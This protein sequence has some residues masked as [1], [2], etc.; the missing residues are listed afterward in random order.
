MVV[1]AATLGKV[2]IV[3]QAGIRAATAAKVDIV[4]REN[5]DAENT[6]GENIA[7]R[8]VIVAKQT[9]VA[10]KAMEAKAGLVAVMA[11]EA[12]TVRLDMAGKKAGAMRDAK[13]PKDKAGAAI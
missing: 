4:H 3:V 9:G 12:G 7:A 8:L 2:V 5:T 11:P 13:G 10:V 6:D 1:Q